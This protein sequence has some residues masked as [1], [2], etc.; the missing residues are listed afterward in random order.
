MDTNIVIQPDSYDNWLWEPYPTYNESD[1]W[2][3][4]NGQGGG[5]RSASILYFDLSS[6]LNYRISSAVLGLYYYSYNG[7]NPTGKVCT[8]SRLLRTNW[9][10]TTSNWNNY[11][12]G[13]SWTTAGALSDGNDFT[14]VNQATATIPASVQQWVYWDVT[15]IANDALRNLLTSLH[16]KLSMEATGGQYEA[17]FSS[18]NAYWDGATTRPKLTLNLVNHLFFCI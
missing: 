18:L 4:L 11:K 12:S 2:I 9:S 13:S 3:N 6:Y 5:Q 17:I 15:A 14:S 1:H 16:I 8:A 7:N 10:Q